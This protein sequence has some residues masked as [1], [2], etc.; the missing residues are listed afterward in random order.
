M[1]RG[2][3]AT[4]LKI[5]AGAFSFLLMLYGLAAMRGLDF[6]QDT[7]LC[8]AYSALPLLS[9]PLH[10]LTLAVRRLLPM[11]A[12][13]LLAYIPVYSSLNW[14][15]CAELGYCGSVAS[16]VFTTIATSKVLLFW[17]VAL[18]SFAAFVVERSGKHRED[19]LTRQPH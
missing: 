4:E 18:A 15:T 11:Q 12:L 10:L 17:G 2:R 6:R 8:V 5:A 14:R 16:V 1:M 19:S 13:L 3:R 9:L 7:A